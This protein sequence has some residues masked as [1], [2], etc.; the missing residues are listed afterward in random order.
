[1][2]KHYDFAA[3]PDEFPEAMAAAT[4][5]GA[6]DVLALKPKATSVRDVSDR[7][8]PGCARG[9][10]EALKQAYNAGYW[11]GSLINR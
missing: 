8:A 7:L 9:Y 5:M 11:S 3:R 10:A 4:R 2:I 6:M 1:V